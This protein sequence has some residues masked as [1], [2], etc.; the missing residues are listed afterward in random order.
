M[1]HWNVNIPTDDGHSIH[2]LRFAMGPNV[3][4][5]R[6][7]DHGLIRRNTFYW[8]AYSNIVVGWTSS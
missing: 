2:G 5:G 7:R 8:R 4:L 1:D 6:D 3:F